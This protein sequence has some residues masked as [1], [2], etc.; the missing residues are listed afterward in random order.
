MNPITVPTLGRKIILLYIQ[1]RH[2]HDMLA[3]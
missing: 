1:D 2:F 3:L